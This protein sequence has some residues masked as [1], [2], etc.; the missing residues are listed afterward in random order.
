MTSPIISPRLFKFLRELKKNN[1]R[2]WFAENKAR[3]ESDVREPA[4][5]LVRRLE[6]PLS[7]AAPM[8]G[9]VP[10]GHGGSVMRIYR[11]TRF[12][13]DKTPYKTNVGISI[14]HQA[15]GNIHAPGIYLHLASDECFIATGCWRP[16][17]TT[18]AAIRAAIAEDPKAWKRARDNKSFRAVY[19]FAGESLKTSPRD[20]DKDHPMIDDLKRIDFIAVAP[21]QRQQITS[22][23]V[24]DLVIDHVKKAKPL[25]RFLCDAID[26]PY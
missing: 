18:L 21:L 12:S 7:R 13:K 24:V 20:Y 2:D 14:R 19:S 4:V 11:D 26:V 6:K 25:M 5:E 23:E 10:K 22:D 3:Y 17:R 8:L 16:E 9:V 1:D 15:D